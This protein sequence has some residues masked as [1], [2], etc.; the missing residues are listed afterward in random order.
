MR[1][2]QI[3][4]AQCANAVYN[5]LIQNLSNHMADDVQNINDP[6]TQQD[7]VAS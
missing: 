5:V 4:V 3:F 1:I 7:C 2:K 6:A